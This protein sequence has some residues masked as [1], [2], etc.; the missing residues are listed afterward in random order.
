[1]EKKSFNISVIF[2]C[3]TLK[4]NMRGED[5]TLKLNVCSEGSDESVSFPPKHDMWSHVSF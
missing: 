1:M 5:E 2:I 4:S 3:G